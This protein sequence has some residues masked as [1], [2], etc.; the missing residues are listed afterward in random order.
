MTEAEETVNYPTEFLN[1]FRK[2]KQPEHCNN[3]QSK[4]YRVTQHHP[5]NPFIPSD[6]TFQF[7]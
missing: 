4:N 1:S 2:T 5:G 6:T 7:K 3:L